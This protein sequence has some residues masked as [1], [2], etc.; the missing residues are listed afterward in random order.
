MS[1]MPSK[2]SYCQGRLV[3]LGSGDREAI[4]KWQQLDAGI[5]ELVIEPEMDVDMITFWK[6]RI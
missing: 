5:G 3:L 2:K 1:P 4:T 6:E